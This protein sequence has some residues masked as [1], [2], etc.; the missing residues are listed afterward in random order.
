MNKFFVFVA[1]FGAIGLVALVGG[2]AMSFESG[3]AMQPMGAVTG[4]EQEFKNLDSGDK[5]YLTYYDFRG[6]DSIGKIKGNAPIGNSY[7][8]FLSAD[9]RGDGRLTMGEFCS[10]KNRE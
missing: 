8:R 1:L 6:D 5:G 3:H 9:S 2:R 4:C 7:T 10:W